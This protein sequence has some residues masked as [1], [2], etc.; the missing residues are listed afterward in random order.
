MTTYQKYNLCIGFVLEQLEG[1]NENKTKQKQ[2]KQTKTVLYQNYQISTHIT[3]LVFNENTKIFCAKTEDKTAYHNGPNILETK[4]VDKNIM[5]YTY[6]FTKVFGK[7][8][9]DGCTEMFFFMLRGAIDQ[10]ANALARRLAW[11]VIAC[12]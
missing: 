11:L 2:N 8:D 10:P 3:C 9:S 12:T 6:I 7:F 1:K 5:L 4:T